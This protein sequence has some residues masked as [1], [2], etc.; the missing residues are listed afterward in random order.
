MRHLAVPTSVA[1][2]FSVVIATPALAA[3]P[4]ND[5]YTGRTT[6][7]ALPFSETLDTTE[8]TTDA[9]DVELNAE[10]GAPATDASVWYEFTAT[11]DMGVLVDVSASD[12]SAGVLV[13][14][15]AP[16]SFS[17]V[18]CGPAGVI[19]F[20]ESGVTYAILAIDDQLDEAGT[21]GT[22][23]ISVDEAPP[24][25]EIDITVD[26]T[27][28]FNPQTGSATISGTVTCSGDADFAS[29]EV[30][31]RQ[32]VGRFVITGFGWMDP[33]CDGTTQPWS[34]EVTGSNGLF[35]GGQAVAVTFAI[36]C[37]EFD[38]GFDFEEATVR[39]RGK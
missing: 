4:T 32:R 13:G 2:L 24:P 8:A 21:G 27:G 5:L 17:I 7:G 34:I 9:D 6:I 31:L 35:K 15:G 18:S 29:V 36:A 10:C 33:F 22:L 14:T 26:P 28:T 39:L 11:A 12:Y 3:A 1:L 30:E 20:A 38:C 37:G 25:P 23:V 16:G 19:F